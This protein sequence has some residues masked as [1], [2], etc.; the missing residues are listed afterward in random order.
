MRIREEQCGFRQGIGC[1]DQVV[2]VSRFVKSI[3]QMGKMYSG[4]L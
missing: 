1:M 4:R 3:W 2:A